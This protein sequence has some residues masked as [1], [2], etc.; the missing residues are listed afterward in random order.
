MSATT[1][2]S[3]VATRAA[4]VT[5]T[6]HEP[7]GGA[8]LACTA[9]REQALRSSLARVKRAAGAAQISSTSELCGWVSR[10]DSGCS[11]YLLPFEPALTVNSRHDAIGT[12]G[13][14]GQV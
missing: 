10:L 11:R 14:E 8:V 7:A 3:A 9:C 12:K 13:M 1:K 4:R 5:T 6:R 2:A